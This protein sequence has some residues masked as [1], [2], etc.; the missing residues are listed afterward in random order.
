[1]L[2]RRNLK[3]LNTKIET[4]PYF[5]LKMSLQ[6]IT[7]DDL[8]INGRYFVREGNETYFGTF[9][10]KEGDHIRIVGGNITY[11]SVS[12]MYFHTNRYYGI[13]VYKYIPWLRYEW[14]QYWLN[15]ILCNITGDETFDYSIMP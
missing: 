4:L 12:N 1:V 14:E 15:Q 3:K 8:K 6:E 7:I 2:N 13:T 9:L 11:S 5:F 10:G